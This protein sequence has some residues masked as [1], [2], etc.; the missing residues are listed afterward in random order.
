MP[1]LEL[2]LCCFFHVQASLAH[3]LSS[4]GDG[5]TAT[6]TTMTAMHHA[7]GRT[8]FHVLS[9]AGLRSETNDMVM[10]TGWT[11]LPHES[12]EEVLYLHLQQLTSELQDL[13]SPFNNHFSRLVSISKTFNQDLLPL[14]RKARDKGSR[15]QVELQEATS[16][17]LWKPPGDLD[18]RLDTGI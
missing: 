10:K 15:R 17:A 12:R 6:G 5:R 13:G 1:V 9:I 2:G 11:N 18:S 4:S 14:L 3:Q 16:K 7:K 8:I